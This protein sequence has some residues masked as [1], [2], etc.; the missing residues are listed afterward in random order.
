MLRKAEQVDVP[1]HPTPKIECLLCS[2]QIFKLIFQKNQ[3]FYYK[4]T[5]CSLVRLYPG[6]DNAAAVNAYDDYLSS[7]KQIIADW[8]RMMRLPIQRAADL[9]Q[10]HA[11][12]R[13]KAKPGKVLDVGCGYGFFLKEMARRGW[14]VQGL[15]ISPAGRRY[16]REQLRLPVSGQPVEQ[17]RW[18]DDCFDVITLFYVIEHL[19]DPK[20]MLNR[21]RNWLKPKGVLLLRWPH[22]TPIV[23]LLGPLAR[24][25]DIYHSPYHLF[26]FSPGAIGMLLKQCGYDPVITCTGGYTLPANPILGICSCG[27]GVLAQAVEKATRYKILLPGVSKTTLAVKSD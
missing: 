23:R 24:K 26:D 13:E 16:A 21:L 8:Q 20:A 27:F 4:C 6:P 15:E 10:A 19:V 18:P 17:A 12:A 25:F 9:I 3:Y 22:S 1:V 5:R 2:G 11:P 7:D 14:R